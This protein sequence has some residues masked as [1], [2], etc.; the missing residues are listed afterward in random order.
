MKYFCNVLLLA[1]MLF[2]SIAFSV[3]VPR[4]WDVVDRLGGAMVF[5]QRRPGQSRPEWSPL[6]PE[7]PMRPGLPPVIQMGPGNRP[8]LIGGAIPVRVLPA[9]ITVPAPSEV[10]TMAA[11]S[12]PVQTVASDNFNFTC[13]FDKEINSYKVNEQIVFRFDLTSKIANPPATTLYVDWTRTGDD[14]QTAKGKNEIT[15]DKP[16]GLATKLDRPGFIHMEANLVDVTGR[17]IASF[18]GGAGVDLANIKAAAEEPPDFDAYWQKQI[19]EL[20]EIPIMA[21][22]KRVSS[23]GAA[24]NVYAVVIP[25]SGPRPATGYL[26]IPAKAKPVSLPAELHLQAYGMRVPA[27][28]TNPPKDRIYFD[29]NAHGLNLGE[30]SAY[31]NNFSKAIGHYAYDVKENSNRDTAYFKYMLLRLVRACQYI[32]G[33]P[34]WNRKDFKVWGYS[35]GGLQTLWAAALVPGISEADPGMPWSCNLGGAVID[36]RLKGT[37]PEYTEALNY[38]DPVFFAK[39]IP[40][41][42]FVYFI[43]TG[44]GDYVSPPSSVT[45]VYNSVP[46]PKKIT[47]YQGIGHEEPKAD[48][49]AYT[50]DPSAT[51]V[52]TP[53]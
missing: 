20:N 22:V 15:M 28:P 37:C 16:L 45:A 42:C 40:A 25:C 32:E 14:G 8:I 7:P 26:S 3:Q 17:K 10:T 13:S 9:E 27:I 5:E 39:R 34:Q 43:R 12:P 44:L 36:G 19:A 29:L 50:I 4:G 23:D 41:S 53:L 48:S 49:K 24:V 38:Y 18:N 52:V 35:Q 47:Y 1:C 11:V 46:G 31:Y 30:N 33:L 2:P 6:R 51:V 21:E